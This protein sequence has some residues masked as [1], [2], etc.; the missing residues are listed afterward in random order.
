MDNQQLF[1]V[2]Q[3]VRITEGDFSGQEAKVGAV[4]ST[5][6]GFEDLLLRLRGYQGT[7]YT[8]YQNQLE[9]TQ[10]PPPPIPSQTGYGEVSE[11]MSQL[12]DKYQQVDSQ[13][14]E[15][16]RTEFQHL[17]QEMA[18]LRRAVGTKEVRISVEQPQPMTNLP[19]PDLE[20]KEVQKMQE[21]AA[22]N[23]DQLELLPDIEI[24]QE[25]EDGTDEHGSTESRTE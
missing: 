4:Q 20:W 8:R 16:L 3:M 12:A 9:S 2:G 13:V 10:P 18:E 14:V 21:H 15:V 17:R 6:Y 1:N 22:S 25:I 5:Q 23:G 11:V 7:R 19:A 24:E